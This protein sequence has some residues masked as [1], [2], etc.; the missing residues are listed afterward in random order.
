[1][2]LQ[3]NPFP[4]ANVGSRTDSKTEGKQNRAPAVEWEADTVAFW[5]TQWLA[6][7]MA[8]P[9]VLAALASLVRA[10]Q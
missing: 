8:S 6:L 3:K 1:M 5:R 7:P 9:R 2:T 4:R 10:F